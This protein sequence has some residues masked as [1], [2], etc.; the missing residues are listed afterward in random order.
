MNKQP[1]FK[2]CRRLGEA[3]FSKCE[4]PRFNAAK[5]SKEQRGGRKTKG[6]RSLS[7]YGTQLLDK[8]RVRYTYNLRERQ[9]A[10]YVREAS[11]KKGVNPTEYLYRTLESRLDNVIF[12]LGFAKS[13][14]AARQ[15]VSHGHIVVNG[16][17]VKAPS[18][19]VSPGDTIG[20]RKESRNKTLFGEL[21]AR[22]KDR[23]FPKWLVVND[24]GTEGEV[25][26]AP[27]PETATG[28]AMNLTSVLEFYGR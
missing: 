21:P 17:K 11:L 16:K 6:G 8:Q 18:F 20:I 3:V 1:K 22:L 10:R 14:A 24:Q 12:R 9:F 5:T 27:I 26:D 25:K 15:L 28:D 19:S 23:V 13:R 7:E 4:N 2:I